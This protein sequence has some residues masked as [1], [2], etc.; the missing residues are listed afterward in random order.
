MSASLTNSTKQLDKTTTT[1]AEVFNNQQTNKTSKINFNYNNSKNSPSEQ[2]TSSII[3]NTCGELGTIV[4]DKEKM[5]SS[6]NKQQSARKDSDKQRS[7]NN[8]N[9]NINNDNA[10]ANESF[11]AS[12]TVPVNFMSKFRDKDTRVLKNLNSSQFIEVWNNYDKDGKFLFLF[13]F[14]E[15]RISFSFLIH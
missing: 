14:L 10:N 2:E 5:D 12:S 7:N 13:P 9:S 3:S 8:N 11:G 6:M 15:M 4:R 1:T